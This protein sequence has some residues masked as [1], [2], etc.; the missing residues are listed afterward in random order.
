MR[1]HTFTPYFLC[2]LL[3]RTPLQITHGC[4]STEITQ[5]IITFATN[6]NIEYERRYILYTREIS[7]LFSEA[8]FTNTD[9]F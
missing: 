1:L 2:V 9:W 3:V 4:V 7:Q 5:I 8:I 6:M